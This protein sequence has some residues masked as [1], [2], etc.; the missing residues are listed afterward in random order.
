MHV[1]T[2]GRRSRSSSSQRADPGVPRSLVVA[3][4][5]SWRLLAV[6]GVVWFATGFLGGLTIVTVPL[7]LS[8]LLAALLRRPAIFLR[9]FLPR[10]LAGVLTVLG[11]LALLGGV[12]WFVQYRV[13]GQ[14][15]TLTTQ[16]EAILGE[17]RDRVSSLPGIGG[18]SSSAVDRLNTW[19]QEH[20]STLLNGAFTAG[21]VA[22]D[23]LTG[24]VLTVFLTLFFLI[25]GER[26]WAWTV[27]L[28][29]RDARPA[30]NGAGY[31][32][33]SVL[34]GWITG[35]AVIATI[36]AVVIGLALWFLGT[37]LVAVLAVLVFIGSFIPIVGAF[38][39]GGFACLVTLVTVGLR[40][41]LILL[42]VLIIENLLE[43]HVYQPL[44]MGR[45][46]KLHP[47]AILL[48]IAAGSVLDGV[49]GAI[50]AIPL[51]GSISAAVKYLRGIEDLHGNPLSD[52][53]R[54]APEPPPLA[55]VPGGSPGP[56]RAQGRRSP[57]ARVSP[58]P[59]R[60][61]SA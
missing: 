17:L 1:H 2:A 8:L 56:V 29:P 5:W 18:G 51:A 22:V 55:L 32:A 14:V 57:A 48:A 46:V 10:S 16:A 7:V 40:G 47:V 30:V 59:A 61:R 42:G 37:P 15:G 27:R 44:I 20:S 3:A 11:A 4:A 21:Q 39:F 35:T 36:H 54:M 38:V 13:R 12:V 53:D 28:L 45:T 33:F 25:D 43:G 41:A 9:R 58:D 19:V 60:S 6:G 49:V 26:I 50:I 24:V 34:S 23:V 31:R 52:V